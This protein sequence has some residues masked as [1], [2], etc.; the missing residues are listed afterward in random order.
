MPL[1]AVSASDSKSM[2][3]GFLKM[4][5]LTLSQ[6]SLGVFYAKNSIKLGSLKI[7]ILANVNFF[8]F[9]GSSAI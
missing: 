2:R 3:Y 7:T 6:I 9:G 5:V 8:S 4:P 1:T